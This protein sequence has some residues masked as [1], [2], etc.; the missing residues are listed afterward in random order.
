MKVLASLLSLALAHSP[1]AMAAEAKT[2]PADLAHRFAYD[3][4]QPLGET[5]TLLYEHDGVRT[6]DLVYT[7]PKGGK[8]TGFVVA[9]VGP[10]PFAGIVFGHW[11]PGNRTE[12]L[13][14]AAL[15]AQ[16]GAVSVMIDYPWVRPAPWRVNQGRG[17][18][19]PEKDRA[20]WEA[21][22]VDLRRALDLL[23]SRSDVD[24]TRIGYVGH[25]YGAQWG[26]ILTAVDHRIKATVLVGGVPSS[27]ATTVEIDDPDMV[28]MIKAHTKEQIDHYFEVNRPYDAI[29]YVP[30]AA[31]TPL[32]FQ[33]ARHERFLN[34]APMK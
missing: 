4:T 32:F 24:R 10:G 12:F 33:F 20:S 15:Y 17:F 8:V 31:P 25:S 23:T 3:A 21:A 2:L 30:F 16:A 22:V 5:L 34:D 19:E 14:E 27:E 28:E 1:G 11:G 29:R 6:F 18:A 26:A 9:P 13:P 7:S